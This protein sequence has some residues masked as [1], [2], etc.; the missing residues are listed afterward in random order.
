MFKDHWSLLYQSV[1]TLIKLCNVFGSQYP[2]LKPR[3]VIEFY[4]SWT[5]E[6]P[7]DLVRGAGG[8]IV[9]R[10]QGGGFICAAVGSGVLCRIGENSVRGD[11]SGVKV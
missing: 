8:N 5:G 2:N 1:R 3:L 11:G 4:G 10:A 6:G 7:V 9:D